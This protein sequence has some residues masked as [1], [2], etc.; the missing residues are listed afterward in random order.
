MSKQSYEDY[1]KKS[2]VSCFNEEPAPKK[3]KS[4]C[5]GIN[6]TTT[7]GTSSETQNNC[8]DK[9]TLSEDQERVVNEIID[10]PAQNFFITGE[11]GTGKS[12]ILLELK[13]RWAD[14]IH[15]AACLSPTGVAA[16]NIG[17][18]T[19]HSCFKLGKMD[20]FC[21]VIIE[22]A[23]YKMAEEGFPYKTVVF[24][25][26]S[27]ISR[28]IMVLV[29]VILRQKLNE[30]LPFGGLQI[31]LFGDFFQLPPV[32]RDEERMYYFSKLNMKDKKD[33]LEDG[34]CFGNLDKKNENV[35]VLSD[36][37]KSLNLRVFYLK[38]N[39]RQISDPTFQKIL[40]QFRHGHIDDETV[41]AFL[42][43]KK[44]E[45][46]PDKKRPIILAGK[47]KTVDNINSAEYKK[48]TDKE[49]VYNAEIIWS[50]SCTFSKYEKVVY[51]NKF[52][53][54][55]GL[56]RSIAL[57]K[58]VYAMLR[59]NVDP[60]SGLYNGT[61]GQIVDCESDSVK[62]EKVHD[63]LM[64]SCKKV[65][66]K[67]KINNSTKNSFTVTQIP[68]SYAWAITFHKSQGLTFE[69]AIL[70][71][72]RNEIFLPHQAYVGLSRVKNMEN[73]YFTNINRSDVKK[74]L[75]TQKE[76]LLLDKL[77]RESNSFT[78]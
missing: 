71:F 3:V 39:F 7:N 26:V 20:S 74:L 15:S 67:Q 59:Y 56:S 44:W 13:K 68:F 53:E 55:S 21:D 45:D 9:N 8:S 58:G 23:L 42:M 17:G 54:D 11:A 30:N 65:T 34:F 1:F 2:M 10:N 37:W 19:I 63:S 77:L 43:K 50:P 75:R 46:A 18:S 64:V 69:S 29:D 38:H 36:V 40:N 78:D 16:F 12:R 35:L 76:V 14:N 52:F 60:R 49:T 72:S 41:D 31:V 4:D 5:T 57:R 48:L 62:F 22:Q 27:M 70:N 6:D 61:R 33:L 24:D 47:R 32:I 28:K 25:E 51:E 66:F 73:I